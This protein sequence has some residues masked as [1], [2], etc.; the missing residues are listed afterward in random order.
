MYKSMLKWVAIG[1]LTVFGI[2]LLGNVSNLFI[3]E[4]P[5]RIAL[6]ISMS[7]KLQTVSSKIPHTTVADED[8]G[9]LS[10]PYGSAQEYIAKATKVSGVYQA[11]SVPLEHPQ[12]SPRFYFYTLGK[13]MVNYLRGDLG[14]VVTGTGK[15]KIPAT[16]AIK[17]MIPRTF[18][19]FIPSLVTAL[20]LSMLFSLLASQNRRSGKVLDGIHAL[21][22]SVPDF[23]LVTLITF[24]AIIVYKNLHIRLA[25]VVQFGDQVPF[26]IPFLTTAL[27]PGVMI[28]GTLR[29]AFQREL[30]QNYVVT[31]RAKGLSQAEVLWKHVLRNVM[32]DLLAVLPKATTAALASMAVAEAACDILGLGGFI[33]SPRMQG[34]S[35]LPLTCLALAVVSM[36]FHGLYALLRKRYV[37]S[38]KEVSA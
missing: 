15:A 28:Y 10:I 16:E 34:V 36:L 12:I 13:Q 29:L 3:N 22:V 21:L 4:S 31:A 14:V 2:F 23:F 17:E 24:L 38:T 32:E 18:R 26:L 25:L 9:I 1:L 19:Y 6:K 8:H 7:E 5:D 37:V 27:I 20:V 33:V 11:M 30:S 35:M